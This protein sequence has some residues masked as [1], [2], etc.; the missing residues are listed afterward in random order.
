MTLL[1]PTLFGPV[2]DYACNIAASNINKSIYSVLIII[3]D[4]EI[5]DMEATIE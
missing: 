1:G 4:G 5:H 3:T 2:I